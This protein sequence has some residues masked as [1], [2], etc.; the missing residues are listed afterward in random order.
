MASVML[1]DLDCDR[2]VG[3]SGIVAILPGCKNDADLGIGDNGDDCI[4]GTAGEVAF[5]T[6]KNPGKTHCLL[7]K[8]SS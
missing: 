4:M 5:C 2:V 1:L 8:F 6:Q 7:F 3:P